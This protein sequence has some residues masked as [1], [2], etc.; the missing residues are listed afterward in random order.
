MPYLLQ[1]DDWITAS[2]L[3]SFILIVWA[4]S[5]SWT[6]IEGWWASFFRFENKRKMFTKRLDVQLNGC[7]PIV[8]SVSLLV[9]ILVT[10]YTYQT[11]PEVFQ[12]LTSNGIFAIG[13]GGI[14]TVILLRLLLY[15]IVNSI[16][17]TKEQTEEWTT[18]YLVTLLYEAILLLPLV[19]STVFLDL[20]IGGQ[21]WWF[22]SILCVIEL[23]RLIKLKVIFFRG[24][25]GYVHI[26]LYFCTLN[27]ATSLISWRLLTQIKLLL[28]TVK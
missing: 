20:P 18:A 4:A 1:N 16:F 14:L 15:F 8:M 27:L 25:L 28:D 10:G 19:A 12:E 9:G 26:F 17:F 2:F 3:L 21:K 13:A 6:F 5:R 7:V 23:I 11:A 22:I 24:L